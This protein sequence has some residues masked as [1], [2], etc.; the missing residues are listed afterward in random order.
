LCARAAF[1]AAAARLALHCGFAQNPALGNFAAL[2]YA[3]LLHVRFC[4]CGFPR[5][6]RIHNA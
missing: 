2:I 6:L 3:M 4:M 5:V 1:D